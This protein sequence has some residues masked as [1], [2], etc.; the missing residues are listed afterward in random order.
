[1]SDLYYFLAEVFGLIANVG[2]TAFVLIFLVGYAKAWSTWTNQ[3]QAEPE[4]DVVDVEFTVVPSAALPAS[5]EVMA[6]VKQVR[7]E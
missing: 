6:M 7:W 4:E 2:A 5:K 1:M 3:Q